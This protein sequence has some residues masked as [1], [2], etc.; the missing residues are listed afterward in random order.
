MVDLQSSMPLGP[1]RV[2][3]TSHNPADVAASPPVGPR[4]EQ[5]QGLEQNDISPT[6]HAPSTSQNA[7]A[8]QLNV[9]LSQ[10]KPQGPYNMVSLA[11]GLPQVPYRNAQYSSGSQQRYNPANSSHMMHQPPHMS[12]YGPPSSMPVGNQGY[13]TQHPPHVPQFYGAGHMSP[14]HS[15]SSMPSRQSVPYYPNQMVMSG[16]S[17]APYYYPPAVPYAAPNQGMPNNM[18]GPGQYT[19]GAAKVAADPRNKGQTKELPRAQIQHDG[20]QVQ[21]KANSSRELNRH[22]LTRI[23]EQ[24]G[25]RV[26]GV[27]R[28][29]SLGKVVSQILYLVELLFSS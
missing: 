20:R 1:G 25:V 15:Q 26:L 6:A 21:G 5:P 11:N 18:A 10:P 3:M 14:P 22:G 19:P 13:Y 27:G 17:Q 29:E 24:M 7:F 16:P 23:E 28:H 8:A 4:Q 9:G 12:Q 2:D